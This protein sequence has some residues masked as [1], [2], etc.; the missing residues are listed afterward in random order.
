MQSATKKARRLRPS[1]VTE[2]EGIRIE[3]GS[4]NVFADLGL[5]GPD[6]RLAKSRLA[7]LITEI[8]DKKG[9][10]QAQA[11][12][13]LETLQPTISALRK[14]RLSSITYDRLVKMAL[15]PRSAN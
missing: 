3:E 2:I 5:P 4:G 15:G 6:E 8:I 7:D 11:A 1:D 10:T 13:R 9:W 14:G 12:E